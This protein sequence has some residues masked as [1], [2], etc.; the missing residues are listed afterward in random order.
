[1]AKNLKPALP[2]LDREYDDLL[3]EVR[4]SVLLVSVYPLSLHC[5][6]PLRINNLMLS[7][8]FFSTI[9]VAW[10]TPVSMTTSS[11]SFSTLW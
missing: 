11:L 5:I 6:F 10:C 4:K 7:M 9:T 2:F 1:M 3:T 8:Y